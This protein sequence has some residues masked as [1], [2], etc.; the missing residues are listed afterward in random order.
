[1]KKLI[2]IK[3]ATYRILLRIFGLMGLCFIIEACYGVPET[4]YAS[5]DVSG[6]VRNAADSSA[7]EGMEVRCIVSEYDTLTDTTNAAG[8][9]YFSQLWAMQGDILDIQ[10]RDVDTTQHGNF[11]ETDTIIPISGRDI[12]TKQ[13]ELNFFVKED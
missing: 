13:R 5:I 4:D 6:T 9:Y 8:E 12:T 2:K 10:L 3:T 7:V 1:M 11:N